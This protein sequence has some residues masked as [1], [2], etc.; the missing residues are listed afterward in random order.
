MTTE[1]ENAIINVI[2][3]NR[4]S[5]TEVA[6]V[7]N[8][9]GLLPGIRLMNPGQFVAGKVVY[10]YTYEESNYPLHE[11]I[12]EVPED[13]VVYVDCINCKERAAF[14]HLVSKY[15]LLYRRAK[16]IVVDG[17]IRDVHRTRKDDMAIWARG[18]TPIGCFNREVELKP[19]VRELAESRRQ[20]MD[21]GIL[22]CDDSGCTLI[23]KSA[24]TNELM[25]KLEFIELQEDIWYFCIDTLKWDTFQTVCKKEYLQDKSVL[26]EILRKRLSEFDL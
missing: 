9:T 5:S 4:I 20:E 26:P 14:G 15:L 13:S 18:G 6:D 25:K 24:I 19:Q 16:A 2:N 3:R 23:K 7:L 17:Y 22:V 11:Q 1:L 12:R 21:G 10:T 8:K